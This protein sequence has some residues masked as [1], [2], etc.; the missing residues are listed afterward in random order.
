MRV[1]RPWLHESGVKAPTEGVGVDAAARQ[2]RVNVVPPFGYAQDKPQSK[3]GERDPARRE[4]P[5]LPCGKDGAPG[6]SP[7]RP[8]CGRKT[9]TQDEE[10]HIGIGD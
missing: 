9:Q 6:C 1:G 2:G 7:K 3:K 10:I 5:T 8:G 4:A